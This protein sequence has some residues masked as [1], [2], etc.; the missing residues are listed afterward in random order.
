M[1]KWILFL[2]SAALCLTLVGCGPSYEPEPEPEPLPEPIEPTTLPDPGDLLQPVQEEEVLGQADPVCTDSVDV[3]SIS[4]E[5]FVRAGERVGDLTELGPDEYY[6]IVLHL[7]NNGT[8]DLTW[9]DA[10]VVV[11]NGPSWHWTSGNIPAGSYADLHIYNSNMQTL[12]PGSHTAVWYMDGLEIHRCT[13]MLT[14]DLNWDELVDMPSDEQIDACNASATRRSPYMAFWL[15]IPDDT[16]YTEYSIDFKTDHLPLGSYYSLGNWYMDY[17]GMTG[18][19]NITS[20]YG[21]NGY[22]GCQNIYNGDKIA[23]LSMWDVFATDAS[24]SVSTIHPTMTYPAQAYQSGAFTG[25]GTGAQCLEPYPWEEN[26]WYRVTLKC[27][28]NATTTVEFWVT[29]L[30]TGAQTLV[31]IFDTGLTGSS[32]K[33]KMCV[34]LENYIVEYAGAVRTMEVCNA[35]YLDKATGQWCEVHAGEMFPCGGAIAMDYAGSYDYGAADGR[36]WIWTT[37]VGDYRGGDST[38]VDWGE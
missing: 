18:Y 33:G 9:Q 4:G 15:D 30:E 21:I 27:V 10:W 14:R 11:D 34:F 16:L 25:E 5:S 32:F 1:K 23:I 35:R 19:V 13:F 31:S 36:L 8:G 24:G 6:S 17:S 29:D 2:L 20:E 28:E 38:Y 12:G 7:Q 26:H 3:Y 37:G 22:A